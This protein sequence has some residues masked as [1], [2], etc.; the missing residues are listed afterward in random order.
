MSASDYEGFGLTIAEAMASRCAVIAVAVTSIPEVVGT[1]G[2]LVPRSDPAL[3][4][5]ALA[6]LLAEPATRAAFG[7]AARARAAGFTWDETA[8]RTRAIYAEVLGR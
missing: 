7:T 1:A 3:L 8:W 5:D 6:R 2:L 4:G